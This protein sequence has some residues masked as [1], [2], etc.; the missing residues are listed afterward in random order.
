MSNLHVMRAALAVGC[1]ALAGTA[2]GRDVP[3]YRECTVPIAF[4]D[5]QGERASFVAVAPDLAALRTVKDAQAQAALL[6]KEAVVELD[7]VRGG[8]AF[9][10]AAPV[11]GKLIPFGAENES[12]RS[13]SS[14]ADRNWLAKSLALPSL[15]QTETNTALAALATDGG[16]ESGWGWLADEVTDAPEEKGRLPNDVLADAQEVNPLEAQE[17]ALA[18]A[19]N[20]FPGGSA[21]AR[22]KTE[23]P[24][25][26]AG[27]FPADVSGRDLPSRSAAAEMPRR[28]W[29]E[30]GRADIGAAQDYRAPSAAGEMAQTRKIL[31]D[32]SAAARPD[33]AALRDS[34]LGASGAAPAAVPPAKLVAPVRADATLGGATRAAGT[35]DFGFSSGRGA[36]TPW[37]GGW[38]PSAGSRRSLATSEMP[39]PVATPPATR[40]GLGSG[41]YKPAWD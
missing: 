41:G 15:G 28:D 35:A 8:S 6:G 4:Y 22:Q 14:Q 26:A 13:Q 16:D 23:A 9:G 20:P 17:K 24:S 25:D 30:N 34:L 1:A 36:A 37:Q 2:A 11:P 21:A 19:A 33:F 3:V 40:P 12:R 39:A 7:F 27:A 29:T 10:A 5:E 38:N 18:A 32:F 31:A